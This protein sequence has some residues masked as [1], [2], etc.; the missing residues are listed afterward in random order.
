MVNE[1]ALMSD[2]FH[3]LQMKLCIDEEFVS[4]NALELFTRSTEESG[5]K[6]LKKAM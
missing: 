1:D 3:E 4:L 6:G 2:I 5:S